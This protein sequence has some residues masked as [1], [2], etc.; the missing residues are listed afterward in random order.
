MMTWNW[1]ME[2]LPSHGMACGPILNI[3]N[4]QGARVRGGGGG[5]GGD[6]GGEGRKKEGRRFRRR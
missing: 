2:P 1:D 4:E 3:L 6:G 5:G